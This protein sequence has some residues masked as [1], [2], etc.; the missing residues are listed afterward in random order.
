MELPTAVR[1][2]M[3]G[4]DH[5]VKAAMLRASTSSQL[6]SHSLLAQALQ[7][8]TSKAPGEPAVCAPRSL[9]GVSQVSRIGPNEVREDGGR[10]GSER[11]GPAWWAMQ[12]KAHNFRE[13]EPTELRRLRVALRTQ[14]P[15]WTAEF[16]SY[17]GFGAMMKRLRELLDIEWRCVHRHLD[18][19]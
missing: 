1:I 18:A 7:L 9:L 11:D 14:A 3:G 5:P 2:K 6:A 10:S 12:L 4:L 17:G 16:V 15:T 8:S 19:F 13:L